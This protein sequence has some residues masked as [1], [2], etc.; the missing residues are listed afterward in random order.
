[1]SLSRER[2][3]GLGEEQAPRQALVGLGLNRDGQAVTH[4]SS[5]A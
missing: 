5:L 4:V 1:M 2:A 3:G